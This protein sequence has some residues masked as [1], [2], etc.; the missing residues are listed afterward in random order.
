MSDKIKLSVE[1][2]ELLLPVNE[3]QIGNTKVNIQPLGLHDWAIV[4]KK[5][6]DSVSNWRKVIID[7]ASEKALLIDQ[8]KQ[9]L[10]LISQALDSD[11]IS[12]LT[13]MTNIDEEDLKRL[14]PKIASDLF[15]FCLDVNIESQRGLEKNLTALTGK[16]GA[17]MTIGQNQPATK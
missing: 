12:I 3:F 15:S 4:L 17:I 11:L 6:G 2:W 13:I 8:I 7:N 10:P 14:P 16:I 1:D 9:A 5:L